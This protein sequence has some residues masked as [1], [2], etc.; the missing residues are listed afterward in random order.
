M[1][2]TYR[3]GP[4]CGGCE[5]LAVLRG[6]APPETHY[7]VRNG[8]KYAYVRRRGRLGNWFYKFVGEFHEKADL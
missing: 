7:V 4:V 2:V 3:G 6:E 5:E 8:I 1:L